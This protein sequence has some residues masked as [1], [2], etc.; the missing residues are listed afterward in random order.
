MSAILDSDARTLLI[1]NLVGAIRPSVPPGRTLL[2]LP[3]WQGKIEEM[4][5]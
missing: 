1:P 4:V 2:T 5:E 3:G